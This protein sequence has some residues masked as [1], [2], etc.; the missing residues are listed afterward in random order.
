MEPKEFYTPAEIADILNVKPRTVRDWIH[1]G[2]LK[3]VKVGVW[4]IPKEELEKLLESGT[5]K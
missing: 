4:R 3:A 2:K 5:S 1:Q